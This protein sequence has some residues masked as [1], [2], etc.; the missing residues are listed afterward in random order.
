MSVSRTYMATKR[1]KTQT[2]MDTKRL[3]PHE[4]FLG[5][6]RGLVVGIPPHTREHPVRD[7]RAEQVDR[8]LDH[9][10]VTR[11]RHFG[12][13]PDGLHSLEEAI[14]NDSANAAKSANIHALKD[15]LTEYRYSAA[16]MPTVIK[17]ASSRLMIS[18]VFTL[19]KSSS[20]FY[21]LCFLRL[22][23]TI[24]FTPAPST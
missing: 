1:T 4:P 12:E 22:A 24:F 10:V 2:V 13:A 20:I 6:D 23:S 17:T 18:L 16:A 19:L 9:R 8:H 11:L 3:D 5:S 14:K 15:H 7:R 21:L